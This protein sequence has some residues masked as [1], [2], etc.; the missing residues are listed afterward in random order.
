VKAELTRLNPK[1]EAASATILVCNDAP[2]V[3]FYVC[4][5]TV[6]VELPNINDHVQ[7]DTVISKHQLSYQYAERYNIS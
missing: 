7:I 1:D 2:D 6:V 3:M 4:T 5:V